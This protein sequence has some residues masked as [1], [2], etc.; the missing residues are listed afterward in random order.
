MH[1]EFTPRTVPK[2]AVGAGPLVRLRAR[3]L[4][5]DHILRSNRH[6][7]AGMDR[8]ERKLVGPQVGQ[9]PGSNYDR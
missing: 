1:L 6:A 5:I 3:H 7:R 2:R 4:A 9:E 8:R